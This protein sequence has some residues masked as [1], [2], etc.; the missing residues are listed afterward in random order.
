MGTR[1]GSIWKVENAE[2]GGTAAWTQ[3]NTTPLPAAAISSIDLLGSEDRMLVTLSNYGV[4]SVWMTENGGASWSDLD[5]GRGLPDMPVWWGM[6]DPTNPD[7]LFLAT[8]AGLWQLPSVDGGASWITDPSI[9]TTR[10][11]ML[12]YR[13]AD[14]RLV[15][16]THGRGLWSTTLS[17]QVAPR[18]AV[19]AFLEGAYTGSGS[20]TTSQAFAV[21]IPTEQPY[22][23]DQLG[24]ATQSRADPASVSEMPDDVIDWVLVSLRTGQSPATT[25]QGSEQAALLRRNGTIVAP[26]ENLI[27][28]EGV[29]PGQYYVVLKHRNHLAVMSSQRVDL[30]SGFGSWDFTAGQG[31]AFSTGA[32]PMADLGDNRT[33]LYAADAS[34]DGQITAADFNTFL[35]QT[36]VASEGYNAGDFNLDGQVTA[37]DFNVFLKNSKK[38]AATQVPD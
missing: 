20:M 35:A 16:A 3:I 22:G 4:A 29:S 7:R 19:S 1:T 14:G 13:V 2:V 32:A 10:V 17:N 31:R 6:A 23:S 5:S 26:D 25:V 9:P 37:V 27:E 8:E 34:A 36:K 28:F 18:L 33:G 11:A 38:S 21:A 30:S 24:E 15:A 12:S